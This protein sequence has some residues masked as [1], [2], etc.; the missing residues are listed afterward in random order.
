M[1]FDSF[2]CVCLDSYSFHSLGKNALVLVVSIAAKDFPGDFTVYL[3]TLAFFRILKEAFSVHDL[4]HIFTTF[5]VF[6]VVV[7]VFG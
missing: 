3:T 5:T 1:Y 4:G 7:V 6:V 2:C